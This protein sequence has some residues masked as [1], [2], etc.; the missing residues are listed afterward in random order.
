MDATSVTNKGQVTIPKELRQKLGIRQGSRVEFSLV[1][2]HVVMRVR[3]SPAS[4]SD[5][6][7]GMLKSRRATVPADLDP[8]SLVKR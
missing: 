2:D 3:S 1:G 4:E 8:A 6:G 5:S 7:F